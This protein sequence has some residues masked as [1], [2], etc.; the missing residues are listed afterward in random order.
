MSLLWRWLWG[1]GSSK[2]L[3]D[4]ADSAVNSH[5]GP[6][7]PGRIDQIASREYIL[8]AFPASSLQAVERLCLARCP[9]LLS[10]ASISRFHPSLSSLASMQA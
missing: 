6:Y 7:D 5:F 1:N 3:S 9:S 4:E 2:S 8:L 10:L